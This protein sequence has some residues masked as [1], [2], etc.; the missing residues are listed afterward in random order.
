[1]AALVGH[2]G[3]TIIGR[4]NERPPDGFVG[5]AVHYRPTQD[6]RG[7]HHAAATLCE[8]RQKRTA[9]NHRHSRRKSPNRQRKNSKICHSE[10][11]SVFER[12]EESAFS[13]TFL[14]TGRPLT[15]KRHGSG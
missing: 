11:R 6:I 12:A 2:R 8:Y 9:T 5:H 7:W 10:P 4:I 13:L 1:M 15:R 3:K 14:R